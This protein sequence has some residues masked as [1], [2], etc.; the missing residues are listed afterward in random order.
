MASVK[1]EYIE[2][3]KHGKVL[4]R[5]CISCGTQHMVTVYFC[6]KCGGDGFVNAELPGIGTVATYTIITV[7]PSGFEKYTPYAFVVMN[8]DGTEERISGFLGGVATPADLPVGHPIRVSGYDERGIIM[9]K[10]VK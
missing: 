9:T 5:E 6:R 8:V 10:I 2:A 3:A 4:L 1:S 7:P